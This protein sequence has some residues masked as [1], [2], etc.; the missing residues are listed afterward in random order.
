[1][2]A[3]GLDPRRPCSC[4][5]HST[6][7]ALKPS[8]SPSVVCSWSPHS[9]RTW[10]A[11]PGDSVTQAPLSGEERPPW[12]PS[13][14]EMEQLQKLGSPLPPCSGSSQLPPDAWGGLD[15][16]R[17]QTQVSPQIRG[18]VMRSCSPFPM[19]S[20]WGSPFPRV[21]PDG[22]E[23]QESEPGQVS[24]RRGRSQAAG[25]GPPGRLQDSSP[26]EIEGGVII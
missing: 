9:A 3:C 22:M 14:S 5:S 17:D 24:V 16:F 20:H 8:V 6:A 21:T 15:V 4:P 18:L 19:S 1:M 2:A 7:A 26:V 25:P 11:P 13:P 23:D 12:D 10:A